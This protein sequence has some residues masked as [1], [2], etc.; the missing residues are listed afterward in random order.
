MLGDLFIQYLDVIIVAAVGA[1]FA[2]KFVAAKRIV[3]QLGKALQSFLKA[4]RDGKW[5]TEEYAAFGKD[6]VPLI[7][8]LILVLKGVLPTKTKI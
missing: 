3:V 1:I 8:D 7:K 4:E 5:S 6:T 2:G